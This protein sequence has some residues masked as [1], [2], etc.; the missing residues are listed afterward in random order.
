M[1]VFLQ[2]SLTSL[3]ARDPRA[4]LHFFPFFEFPRADPSFDE[5][6]LFSFGQVIFSFLQ[7]ELL[8]I[9]LGNASLQPAKEQ[10]KSNCILEYNERIFLPAIIRIEKWVLPEQSWHGSLPTDSPA[11]SPPLL[12]TTFFVLVFCLVPDPHL[13]EQAP[14]YCHWDQ[15]QSTANKKLKTMYYYLKFF[16]N[17]VISGLNSNFLNKILILPQSNSSLPSVHSPISLHLLLN[18]THCPLV[19]VNWSVEQP[20]MRI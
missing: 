18:G 7:L 8:F 16:K 2:N 9:L 6:L 20:L 10:T 1:H 12:S 3:L 4:L 13:F 17:W 15:T 14:V 5:H 11:Q 19:Q